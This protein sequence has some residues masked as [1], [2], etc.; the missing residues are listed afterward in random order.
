MFKSLLIK[1][2]KSIL[3]GLGNTKVTYTKNGPKISINL[4][5]DDIK[6]F[7][8]IVKDGSNK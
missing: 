4:D 1:T 3:L 6:K 8:E 5:D 2:L 7:K